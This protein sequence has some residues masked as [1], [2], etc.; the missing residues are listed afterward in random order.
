MILRK[1]SGFTFFLYCPTFFYNIMPR[2]EIISLFNFILLWLHVLYNFDLSK[3]I[4]CLVFKPNTIQNLS[5]FDQARILTLFFWDFFFSIFNKTKL[6]FSNSAQLS[7]VLL[8]I[9]ILFSWIIFLMF[10]YKNEEHIEHIHYNTVLHPCKM[11]I[12]CYY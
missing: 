1:V 7:R 4:Y 12:E 6:F 9:K 5:I 2:F 3:N 8:K 10:N 11:I